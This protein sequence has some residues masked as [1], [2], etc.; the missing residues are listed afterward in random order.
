MVFCGLWS[1]GPGYGV[2]GAAG[3]RG[4]GGAHSIWNRFE[5][6]HGEE[7]LGQIMLPEIDLQNTLFIELGHLCVCVCVCVCVYMCVGC[8]GVGEDH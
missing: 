1:T 2:R 5:I 4:V 8:G 3:A 7:F 6:F